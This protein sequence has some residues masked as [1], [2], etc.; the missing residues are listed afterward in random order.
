MD[1]MGGGPGVRVLLVAVFT[2]LALFYA[3]RASEV[4]ISLHAP[5][6][7]M[8]VGM[9]YMVLPVAWQV[10]PLALWL[11]VFGAASGWCVARTVGRW[12]RD[13]RLDL[14][15]VHSEL[16]GCLAMTAMLPV[17]TVTA[18]D[19]AALPLTIALGTYFLAYSVFWARNARGGPRAPFAE[20]LIRRTRAEAVAQMTM[21]AGMA[22]MFLVM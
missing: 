20:G 16:M 13:H 19:A 7:L 18:L 10:L 3:V 2:A 6:L 11:V 15:F 4:C 8:A 5:H 12:R 9:V 14:D 1:A 22:F 21:G 17:F